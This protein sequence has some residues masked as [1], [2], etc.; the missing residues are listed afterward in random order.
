MSVA[1]ISTSASV[2]ATGTMH[3]LTADEKNPR[4]R[5]REWEGKDVVG[6]EK[7]GVTA[8]IAGGNLGGKNEGKK[9]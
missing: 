4:Q 1:P 5:G 6:G 3:G 2:G 9:E 8:G 7:D